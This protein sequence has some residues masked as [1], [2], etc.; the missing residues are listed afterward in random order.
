MIWHVLPNLFPYS[1][2]LP[3]PVKVKKID[4][5]LESLPAELTGMYDVVPMQDFLSLVV[6]SNVNPLLFT[7]LALLKPGDFL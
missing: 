4:I 6:D 2:H 3:Q 1:A 5:L 7:I